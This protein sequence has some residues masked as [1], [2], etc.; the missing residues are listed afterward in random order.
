M[1]RDLI[2]TNLDDLPIRGLAIHIIK[3]YVLKSPV[4]ESFRVSNYSILLIKSGKLTVQFQKTDQILVEMDLLVIPSDSFCSIVQFEGKLQFYLITFSFEFAI[5]NSLRQELIEALHFISTRA[6]I[7]IKLDEKEMLILSLIYKVLYFVTRDPAGSGNDKELHRISFNL[8]MYELRLIYAK[9]SNDFAL[10]FTRKE[11][12]II[13][14]L[15]ILSIH[16]RKQ[17]NAQFYAGSLFVTTG[18]LNQMVK[19]ITGKTVKKLIV[20]TIISEAEKLLEDPQNTISQ[21]AEDLEFSSA[22]SF[23]IF[24]KRHTNLSPSQY[25]LSAMEKFKTR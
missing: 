21:I 10:Q 5:K 14:F 4:G 11:S 16:Y 19:E 22:N 2:N 18:Y 25:R 8:F 7:K 24:F 23:T 1:I 20:E 12:L 3:N 17:H 6:S 15:T 9:H 13:R